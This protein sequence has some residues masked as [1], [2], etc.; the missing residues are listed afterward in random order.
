MIFAIYINITRMYN[1]R[2]D[3]GWEVA[4]HRALVITKFAAFRRRDRRVTQLT[5]PF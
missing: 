2:L 1:T 5:G 3:T 4:L